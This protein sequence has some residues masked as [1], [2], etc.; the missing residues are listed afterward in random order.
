LKFTV[1]KKLYLGFSIIL[2]LLLLVAGGNMNMQKMTSSATITSAQIM[3]AG[4][5]AENLKYLI[6]TS[7][8]TG[9][10]YLLSN[11]QQ[12]ADTYFKKENA[13][14]AAVKNAFVNLKQLTGDSEGVTLLEAAVNEYSKYTSSNNQAYQTFQASIKVGPDGKTLVQDEA[15][16]AKAQEQY[17]AAT[18][19]PTLNSIS[20]YSEWLKAKTSQSQQQVSNLETRNNTINIIL[21]LIGLILGG[22]I[23][24]FLSGSMV[25]SL[26][27]LQAASAKIAEGNLTEEVTVQSKDE[28]GELA[29]GFTKM[30]KDLREL[31]REVIDTASTLGATSE[32][33]SAAAE[34][35]TS[36]SE[37]VSNT[38]GQLASGAAD[39]AISV[40]NTGR[41][42]E[43]LSANAR[44]VAMNAESVSQSSGKAAQAAELGALQAENAV[45]KIDKIREVSAQT[46]EAVFQLGDQSKQIGQIVD[47]IKGIAD[48]T[49]LLALNAAIEAARAGE[50]GRGFAVVAEEVRK[51]AEQSSMSATQIATLIGNIQRETDR[52]V[53]VMEKGKAEVVA[54]V[55][56]VTLA[57]NSFQTIVGEVNT[58]VEQIKQVAAATQQMTSGTS[59]AVQSVED[60]GVIAEQSAA[61]TQ[62]V[63]AAAE[64]QSATMAS[65]SQSAEALAQLGE[66]LSHLVS[67]FRV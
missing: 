17:F 38:L 32:E 25:K 7:D 57:G 9:A 45:Q 65:V 5:L 34:E 28:F 3:G 16:V 14:A 23:A 55:E 51:L 6:M 56:A 58:V 40:G 10:Y 24:F 59:Q 15:G 67:K 63:S 44:Q 30:T 43:Q 22:L 33:L 50:Q 37:Q 47:V 62:E 31:I 46:A 41:V 53:E 35:A 64:E 26:Q 20:K 54:G 21:T 61:S 2:L 42:I 48:Q 66:R 60:I 4:V 11:T 49:N 1:R 19:D 29:Q 39:Q 52:A 18:L 12:D 8:D 13:D 27:Q 36:S